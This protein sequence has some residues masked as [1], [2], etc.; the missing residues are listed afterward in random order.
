MRALKGYL[1]YLAA[2]ALGNLGIERSVGNRSGH[3]LNCSFLRHGA[4]GSCIAIFN[5]PCTGSQVQRRWHTAWFWT[6]GLTIGVFRCTSDCRWLP[7]EPE[8]DRTPQWRRVKYMLYHYDKKTSLDLCV[9]VGRAPWRPGPQ[10]RSFSANLRINSTIWRAE[11]FRWFRKNHKKIKW[12][13]FWKWLSKKSS[14]E[15]QKK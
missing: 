3:N 1:R 11:V 8:G 4:P 14:R 7:E 5:V 13:S 10:T 15:K 2:P 9:H 12:L 6:C